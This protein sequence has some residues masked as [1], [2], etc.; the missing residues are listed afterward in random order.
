MNVRVEAFPRSDR[1]SGN[2]RDARLE[3]LLDRHSG[4]NACT[5]VGGAVFLS[6][7]LYS[8]VEFGLLGAQFVN[9][10]GKLGATLLMMFPPSGFEYLPTFLWSLAETIA[11]AFLGTSIAA[12]LALPVAFLAARTTLPVRILQFGFRRFADSLRTLDYLIWALVFV[13]AIGLGPMAGILAIA[14][15]ELGTLIKLYSE[16]IDNCDRR[17]VEGVRAAGGRRLDEIRYGILP[18]IMPNLLSSAL[19]MW[20]SNTRSATILGIVGAG[21]IGYYLADRLRVYEWGEASLIIMLIVSAVYAIDFASSRIRN[22]LISG[23]S[24]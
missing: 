6:V 10:L 9:G 5:W 4:I 20:E 14:V 13:R 8:A 23:V 11:M 15:V 17:P 12:L 2:A 1:D 24:V 18:Q 3:G 21:G 16:A 7:L 22:R 19:Y